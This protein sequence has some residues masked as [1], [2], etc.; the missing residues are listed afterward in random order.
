VA[1]YVL[2]VSGCDLLNQTAVVGEQPLNG[3]V[4][5]PVSLSKP[6]SVLKMLTYLFDRHTPESVQTYADLL[7]EGYVYRYDDAT[8]KNDLE[9]D[10]ASE[11]QVYRNIFR[12]FDTI[13]AQFTV[14]NR[15]VEFG[16]NM[17]FPS[18]TPFYQ[19]SPA[20]P[21]ENWVV[22]RVLG[23]LV[24]TNTDNQAVQSGYQV[25]QRFDIAFRFDPLQPDST[26]QIASWVDRESLLN[27]K[28]T[29][30]N[31]RGTVSTAPLP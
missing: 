3:G 21:T 22:L 27:A 8:D 10:R 19:V 15:W 5:R 28:I 12:S 30:R 23:D 9:L 14:E 1:A 31:Y 7:F 11:L 6:D 2:A 4:T 25:R 16:A 29:R 20:H 18:G 13:S 26:W 24:F 17:P